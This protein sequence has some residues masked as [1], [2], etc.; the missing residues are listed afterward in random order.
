MHFSDAAYKT[1]QMLKGAEAMKQIK[2]ESS[3]YKLENC[4]GEGLSSCVYR[5][6]RFDSRGH[7]KQQVVLKILKNQNQVAWLR[8]EFEALSKIDSKY[9]VRLLAWENLKLGSA[10]VLEYIEGI[11]LFDLLMNSQIDA[12]MVSEILA[13]VQLG[14]TALEQAGRIHGDLNLKNIMLDKEGGVKL[15]DFAT[16]NIGSS[17]SN[18]IVGTPQ[19]LAPEIWAGATR[20]IKSDLFSLGLIAMDLMFGIQNIPCSQ[21]ECKLRAMRSLHSPDS[22]TREIPEAREFRKI[23]RDSEAKEKVG[24]LV[25]SI[26]DKKTTFSQETI[27]IQ[28]PYKLRIGVRTAMAAGFASLCFVT[29][30]VSTPLAKLEKSGEKKQIGQIEVRT[31]RWV[32]VFIDGQ[33]YGYAPLIISKLNSGVHKMKWQTQHSSGE[34]KFKFEAGEFRVFTD[35]DFRSHSFIGGR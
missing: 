6:I 18:E 11:T 31:K 19:Y 16:S 14:L 23:E 17:N 29:P 2:S 10:L 27:R 8:Q 32:E 13:Q 22:L 28:K 33:N 4:I 20:T 24:R 26:L 1:A 7:S 30:V 9:C 5:A 35:A 21:Y 15:I 12:G 25:S 3:I 34:F